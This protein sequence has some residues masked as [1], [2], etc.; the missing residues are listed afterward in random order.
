M[1]TIPDRPTDPSRLT[2]AEIENL[3]PVDVARHMMDVSNRI[4]KGVV[5][6]DAL[7]GAYQA[8]DLAY[9]DAFATAYKA[10][11][12]PA[13]E[14]KYTAVLATIELR[15]A[16]DDAHR[17]YKHGLELLRQLEGDRSMWQTLNRN[18]MQAYNA[19]GVE[20]RYP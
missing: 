8:A 15:Q 18:V 4:A 16:R 13:H 14:K 17:K 7:F 19:V 20:S 3:T 1:T 5:I 2:D 9:D 10:D 11:P 12:G 6:V